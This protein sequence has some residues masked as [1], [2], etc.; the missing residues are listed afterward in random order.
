MWQ[1]RRVALSAI[2]TLTMLTG[3]RAQAPGATAPASEAKPK[4]NDVPP[5]AEPKAEKPSTPGP[6]VAT[7]PGGGSSSPNGKSP[8]PAVVV[9]L[10]TL[11]GVS[12]KAVRSESGEDMGRIT[13]ILVGANGE[14][15]AAV[16]DFGGFLGVGSRKVAVDWQTLNF[17]E[18]IKSGSVKVSLTRD[19]V[20]QSPEYKPDEPVVILEA[21]RPN[22]PPAPASQPATSPGH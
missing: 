22:R 14:P 17:A 10:D 3:A 7:P 16:I 15:R 11:E 8:T 2:V 18:S 1:M 21:S 19:Q 6:A 5:R 9:G 13:D 4:V 12:G 20:R